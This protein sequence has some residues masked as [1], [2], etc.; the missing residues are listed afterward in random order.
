MT[1]ASGPDPKANAVTRRHLTR[2]AWVTGVLAVLVGA[3]G[4]Y[5]QS[6]GYHPQDVNNFHLSDGATV[7]IAAV[8]LLILTVALVAVAR[9]RGG[10]DQDGS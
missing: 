5:M 10:A 7:I 6:S 9:T 4:V 2:L 8:L 1:G 3:D